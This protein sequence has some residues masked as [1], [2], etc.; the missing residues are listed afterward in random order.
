MDKSV[1]GTA[2]L[3]II[4]PIKPPAHLD[5]S[6]V[7]EFFGIS[8]SNVNSGWICASVIPCFLT[9]SCLVSILF[10]QRIWEPLFIFDNRLVFNL[11][12]HISCWKGMS[13]LP[14]FKF[15]H[16]GPRSELTYILISQIGSFYTALKALSRKEVNYGSHATAEQVW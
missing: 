15:Q 10:E 2:W 12:A 4:W 14:S 9:C 5:T 8:G 7:L 13:F 1:S 11:K 3:G 16:Y 6:Y